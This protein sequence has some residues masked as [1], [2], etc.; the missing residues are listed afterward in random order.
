MTKADPNTVTCDGC[1]LASAV[2]ITAPD[3]REIRAEEYLELVRLAG[4]IVLCEPCAQRRH[5]DA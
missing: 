4:M 5:T 1:G 3:G 2:T